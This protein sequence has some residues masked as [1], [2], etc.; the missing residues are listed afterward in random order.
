MNPNKQKEKRS[1]RGN[2]NLLRPN[3]G[4]KTKG[5]QAGKAGAEKGDAVATAPQK[6]QSKIVEDTGD[7]QMSML[8]VKRL[9]GRDEQVWW[10]R[11]PHVMCAHGS[12][13]HVVVLQDGK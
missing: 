3:K 2:D 12:C 8:K 5:S 7:I 1:E 4:N 6:P 9:E 11:G 10:L 13:F